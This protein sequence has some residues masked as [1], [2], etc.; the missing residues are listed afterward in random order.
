MF[1]LVA[2]PRVWEARE[3]GGGM[4]CLVPGQR[5]SSS[6]YKNM[7]I[8]VSVFMISAILSVI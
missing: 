5:C 7:S 3:N 6:M 8:H 2:T 1:A 4:E